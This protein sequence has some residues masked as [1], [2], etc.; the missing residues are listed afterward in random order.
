MT[1]PEIYL[2]VDR[3]ADYPRIFAWRELRGELP[4]DDGD[5]ADY[6]LHLLHIHRL[7]QQ[8][9]ALFR[10]LARAVAAE[11]DAR[12]IHRHWLATRLAFMLLFFRDVNEFLQAA[13]V[14]LQM[15]EQVQP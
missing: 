6:H 9:P 14:S 7:E 4:L 10:A 12:Y 13:F 3:L 8:E 15:Q 5:L 11:C 1:Y 2:I